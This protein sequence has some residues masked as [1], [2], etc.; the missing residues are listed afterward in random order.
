MFASDQNLT[1]MEVN[2][3]PTSPSLNFND[4]FFNKRN[5][6][7]VLEIILGYLSPS[8]LLS[9]QAVCKKWNEEFGEIAQKKVTRL[10][11]HGDI[12]SDN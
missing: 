8:D 10:W 9:C 5:L 6:W 11:R 2:L 12:G 4:A 7:P 3:K 1:A